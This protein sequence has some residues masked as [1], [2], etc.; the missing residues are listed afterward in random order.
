PQAGA[1]GRVTGRR[2][3][4]RPAAT[5]QPL[6]PRCCTIHAGCWRP[7]HGRR[8]HRLSTVEA[9]HGP[10]P[11]GSGGIPPLTGIARASRVWS[12]ILACRF[13]ASRWRSATVSA[14]GRRADERRRAPPGQEAGLVY[15]VE[16]LS[17]PGWVVARP[18]PLPTTTRVARSRSGAVVRWSGRGGPLRR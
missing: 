15:D 16:G 10:S 8:W 5:T 18:I 9:G 3:A 11:T 7:A 4:F 13:G 2:L 12:A 1:S 17:V 14:G 6:P